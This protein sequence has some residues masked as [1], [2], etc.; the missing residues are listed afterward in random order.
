MNK[1]KIMSVRLPKPVDDFLVR[2]CKRNDKNKS[3]VILEGI[4][5]VVG[6]EYTPE[7]YTIPKK[8]NTEKNHQLRIK[9]KR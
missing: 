9:G 4:C 2:Y 7:R 1:D 8:L 5:K 3:Q 6:I